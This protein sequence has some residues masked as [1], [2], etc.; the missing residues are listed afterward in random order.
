MPKPS[1]EFPDRKISETLLDFAQPFA[2]LIDKEMPLETVR[3]GFEFAVVI[4][5]AFVIDGAR[6]NN[7]YKDMIR[8]ALGPS[9]KSDPLIRSLIQRRKTKFA[10]DMRGISDFS[11]R[12]EGTEIVLRAEARSPYPKETH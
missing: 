4:W 11:V 1:P 5:N 8:A 6:G 7:K 9:W 10:D 2:R 3:Q 12:F